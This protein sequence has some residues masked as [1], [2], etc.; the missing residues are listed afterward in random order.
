MASVVSFCLA[1]ALLILSYTYSKRA[2]HPQSQTLAAALIFV[3]VFGAVAGAAFS[4]SV[5][6]LF[7]LDLVGGG[8]QLATAAMLLLAA[9]LGFVAGRWQLKKPP[10]QSPNL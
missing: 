1:A 2:K 5:W 3:T 6:A 8:T 7:T 4:L 9:A 10:L